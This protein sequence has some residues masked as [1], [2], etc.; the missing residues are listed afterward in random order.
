MAPVLEVHDL[1]KSYPWG[2]DR[3][4]ILRGLDLIVERGARIGILGPSGSG[5]STLLHLLAGLDLP[6]RGSVTVLQRDLLGM[7]EEARILFRRQHY[8]FVFQ[9]HH[10]MP[11]LTAL[12]NVMLPLLL[13][14]IGEGEA[15]ERAAELLKELGLGERLH[16]LPGVLSG[17]EQQRV[18]LARAVI[19]QPTL[20]LA[21]EPTGNLDRRN[22]LHLMEY[23]VALNETHG[24]TLLLVTHNPELQRF[25]HHNFRLEDGRLTPWEPSHA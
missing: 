7:P 16:H 10:L 19:H 20:V 1:H 23:L 11:D 13:L 15:R 25:M 17:G 6:D 5:K 14:G 8:G 22:S 24:T 3:L 21:D 2:E 18:A 4:H 12:E 9:F